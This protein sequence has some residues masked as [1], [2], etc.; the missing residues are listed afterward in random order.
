MTTIAALV[1]MRHQSIRVPEKNYRL[2]AGKPLYIYII[3][4]L[5]ALPGDR[6]GRGG[7]R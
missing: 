5:L 2:L 6:S 7:H 3:E 4:A 1:P